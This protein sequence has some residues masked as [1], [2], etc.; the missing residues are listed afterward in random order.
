MRSK[1]A[2]FWILVGAFVGMMLAA[3]SAQ[4]GTFQVSPVR[5]PLSATTTSGLLKVKNESNEQLRFQVTAFSWAQGPDGAMQL[6][7][8]Q[9]VVFFPA[10]LTLK[11]GESRNI[12]VGA[13]VTPG[14]VEKTYRVFVEELPPLGDQ[15]NPNAIRV[16]M[17]MG[18]PIFLEAA[19]PAAT[20]KLDA[21]AVSGQKVSFALMN[22]GTAHFFTKRVHVAALGGDG[23]PLFE[24]DLPAWYVLGGGLRSY[25][26]EL[27]QSACASTRLTV[28]VDTDKT[29]FSSSLALPG[30]ACSR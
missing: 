9:D 15:A 10:M 8:T 12:R 20:P 14:P 24:R 13:V 30:R 19:A 6:A 22:T 23:K 16:R 2:R 25:A 18:I 28:R 3:G 29:S 11:P 17:R 26:L 1:S 5:L 27:P 4:A 7:P 21:L